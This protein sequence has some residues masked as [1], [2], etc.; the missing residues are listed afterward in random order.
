MLPAIH[1]D[2]SDITGGM[3]LTRRRE[4]CKPGNYIL[5]LYGAHPLPN[6]KPSPWVNACVRSCRVGVLCLIPV[7]VLFY[8]LGS[9][10]KQRAEA[11][12]L[13]EEEEARLVSG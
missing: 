1:A 11:K 13:R 2:Q 3:M 8:F 12:R 9:L 5:E 6:K 10:E 7:F 4:Y